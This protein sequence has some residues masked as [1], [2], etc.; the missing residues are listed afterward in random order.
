MLS[1]TRTELGKVADQTRGSDPTLTHGPVPPDAVELEEGLRVGD[2][3]DRY[4]I[5]DLLGAGGMGVVLKAYDPRLKR[6]IALK[7]V[8]GATPTENKRLVREA[9]AMAQ[10]SHANVVAVYDVGEFGDHVFVAM[11]LVDGVDLRGWLQAHEDAHFT[12]ILRLYRQA[13]RGLA[14]VHE[15][16]LVHRDF[17]PDNVLVS[18]DGR[19]LVTD[20]GLARGGEWRPAT[21]HVQSPGS[22]HEPLTVAGAIVGTPTYMSP[23]QWKGEACNERDDQFSFCAALY[24][25]LFGHSAFPG[26]DWRALRDAVLAGDFREPPTTLPVAIRDAIARG[27]SSDRGQRH[28]DMYALIEALQ[29]DPT[30]R[31]RWRFRSAIAAVL[32]ATTASL[33]VAGYAA[34]RQSCAYQAS[35]QLAEAVDLDAVER[36]FVS[37]ERPYLV[38]SWQRLRPSLETY[39]EHWVAAAARVCRVRSKGSSDVQLAT[40][41]QQVCVEKQLQDLSESVKVWAHGDVRALGVAH[42]R[43][44]ELEPPDHCLTNGAFREWG[45][46]WML[47]ERRLTQVRAA[48]NRIAESNAAQF[49][50]RR[51]LTLAEEAVALADASGE[52]AVIGAAKLELAQA[53]INARDPAAAEGVVRELREKSSPARLVGRNELVLEL[54][55]AHLHQYRGRYAEAE[56]AA[57]RVIERSLIEEPLTAAEAYRV[58]AAARSADAKL[59][60][61][62]QDGERAVALERKYRGPRHPRVAAA[63]RS[64]GI[65]HWKNGDLDAAEAA[66]REAVSIQRESV[67]ADHPQLVS[68]ENDLAIVKLESDDLEGARRS[69]EHVLAVRKAQFGDDHPALATS[70]NNVGV[71]YLRMGEVDAAMDAFEHSVQ[72]R[73]KYWGESSAKLISPLNNL[74]DVQVLAGRPEAALVPNARALAIAEASFGSDHVRTAQIRLNRAELLAATGTFEEA[75]RL[76]LDSLAI[77]EERLPA[78]HPNVRWARLSVGVS[79]SHG[80]C[81]R[82]TPYLVQGIESLADDAYARGHAR[83][84]LGRCREDVELVEQAVSDLESTPRTSRALIEARTWLE[85]ARAQELARH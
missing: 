17:K 21:Q 38:E 18:H 71:V 62:V 15:A 76:A 51:A 69:F 9:E 33:L 60:A 40:L 19:V 74:T 1:P 34:H 43:F 11:E 79:L 37:S 55:Q 35:R 45:A 26:D 68:L 83:W 25:S 72:L 58:R 46:D 80:H 53:H 57:T 5:V 27:L 64:L 70:Y 54:V 49:D 3:V 41:R 65:A 75:E 82:A 22:L 39:Q 13:A 44:L 7:L 48:L 66:I 77:V 73:E 16:G 24:E 8:H 20:F 84:R 85:R 47:D 12:E 67:G 63:L 10:I 14:A 23:A 30:K 2:S 31:R 61:A 81:D 52:P 32:A 59:G 50:E 6:N 42:D 28:T 56:A 29:W 36:A 78:D 4:V